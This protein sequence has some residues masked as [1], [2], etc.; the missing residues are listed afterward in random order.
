MAIP[1]PYSEKRGRI[2]LMTG[3][4][5]WNEIPIQ[6]KLQ[7]IFKIPVFWNRMPMQVPWPSTGIMM[8]IIKMELL[9]ILR[10]GRVLVP[11]SSIMVSC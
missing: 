4:L 8:R 7:D 1:G 3:V 9:Y 6:E 5:G 10:L 11:V 2:E